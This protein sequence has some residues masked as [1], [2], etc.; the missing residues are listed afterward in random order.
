MFME[1]LSMYNPEEVCA[2]GVSDAGLRIAK[3]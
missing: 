2:P 1:F 3:R